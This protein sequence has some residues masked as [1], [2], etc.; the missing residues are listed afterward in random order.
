MCRRMHATFV[1]RVSLAEV[2]LG[3]NHTQKQHSKLYR[4]VLSKRE[5][6]GF[7]FVL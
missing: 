5:M 6:D 2:I 3:E 4:M 1:K 7:G